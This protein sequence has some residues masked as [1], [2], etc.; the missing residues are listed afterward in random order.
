M[1]AIAFDF[2]GT[3]FMDT[4]KHRLAWN[5]FF[6]GLIGRPL[7]DEEFRV[8]A[9]GPA[10]DTIIRRFYRAG[11]DDAR[12]AAL[13]EEK[14]AIYRRLCDRFSLEASECLFIDDLPRNIEG[15]QKAGMNGYCFQDGDVARLVGAFAG[16]L[17]G[18]GRGLLPRLGRPRRDAGGSQIVGQTRLAHDATQAAEGHVRHPG[19]GGQD[20]G[21]PQAQRPHAKRGRCGC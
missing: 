5:E 15:A 12:I 7:S 9:C 21:C 20:D 10:V 13:C 3:M 18:R 16:P 2:N 6:Q 8:Y 4:D 11:L 17:R 1:K 19:H 14:E